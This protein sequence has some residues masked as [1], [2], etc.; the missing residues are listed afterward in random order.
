MGTGQEGS[1]TGW[2]PFVFLTQRLGAGSR[3]WKV[4]TAVP[5]VATVLEGT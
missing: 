3:Q 5:V 2:F 1:R 4:E